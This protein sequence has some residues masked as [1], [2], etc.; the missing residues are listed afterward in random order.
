MADPDPLSVL[1]MTDMRTHAKVLTKLVE[2]IFT[3]DELTDFLDSARLASLRAFERKASTRL[4]ITRY[5][6]RPSQGMV[7]GSTGDYDVEEDPVTFESKKFQNIP[8]WRMRRRPVVSIQRV[9]VAYRADSDLIV[10]PNEWMQVTKRTGVV[11]AVPM[12]Q[13]NILVAGMPAW[14]LSMFIQGVRQMDVPN[15]LCFDYTAGW[16]AEADTEL[17]EE[18]EEVHDAIAG[19]AV[20]RLRGDLWDALPNGTNIDG[21]SQQFDSVQ[22]RVDK[23]E[24]AFEKFCGEWRRSHNPSP[25]SVI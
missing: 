25:I 12:G 20:A 18:L 10:L 16:Y 4:V 14:I 3:A 6:Q 11:S 21:F 24:E 17:P 19:L 5:A 1:S 15:I 13:A 8:S 7:K 9:R 22:V 23:A 2:G